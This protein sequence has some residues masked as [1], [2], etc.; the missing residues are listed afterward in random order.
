MAGYSVLIALA[1]GRVTGELLEVLYAAVVLTAMVLVRQ[2]SCC[3]T[4]AACWPNRHAGSRRNDSERWPRTAPMPSF[5]SIARGVTDA[6]P[7]VGRVLGVDLAQLVGR[8]ISRSFT[9][10][11]RN[12][13]RRSSADVAPVGR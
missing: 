11:T 4:T 5:W 2:S 10:T 6:T 3:A 8:P 12:E 1:V 9:A 13:W 7:Q